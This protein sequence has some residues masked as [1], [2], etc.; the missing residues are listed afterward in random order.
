MIDAIFAF[1]LVA[2]VAVVVSNCITIFTNSE[3]GPGCM[4]PVPLEQ[5]VAYGS[6]ILQALRFLSL[7]R[8][9][10]H[11][12]GRFPEYNHLPHAIEAFSVEA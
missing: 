6:E 12:D 2:E 5:I 10:Q 7:Y 9:I 11:H 3:F 4:M 8:F 1:M